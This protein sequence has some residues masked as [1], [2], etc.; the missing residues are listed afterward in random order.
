MDSMADVRTAARRSADGPFMAGAAR[1]GLGSRAV[2]YLV[3]AWLALQIASGHHNHQANQR[4]AMADIVHHTFG[5][6]IVAVLGIGLAAY[7]LW[8]LSQAA[9]GVAGEGTKAG[10]RLQSLARGVIYLGLSVSTF[11]FLAGA[12]TQGQAEQQSTLTARLMRHTSG[13]WLVGAAGLVV[14]VVGLAM[15]RDGL[16]RKFEDQL[17]MNEL[18]ART[19]TAV[20]TLGVVGTAARGIVFAVAGGMV[21]DAAWTFDPGKSAGLDGA[22]RTLADR[23]FG[24]L[25]LGTL[26][27]G[28]AAF[29][30]FGLASA[31]WAKT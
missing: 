4:G 17:R 20:V 22:L 6:V 25:L 10:P 15:I 29:G 24:A 3:I 23:S 31:R 5:S 21:L 12:S 30:L 13:R 19:R 26:S 1:F 8:R 2:V 14:I 7:G 11:T 27:L 18:N 9:F 28:L 16:R